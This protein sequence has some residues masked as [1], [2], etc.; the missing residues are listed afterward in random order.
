MFRLVDEK[1]YFEVGELNIY[2]SSAHR[3]RSKG[4]VFG[5][6]RKPH[7]LFRNFAVSQFRNFCNF[8]ARENHFFTLSEVH[9]RELLYYYY[10]DMIPGVG[11]FSLCTKPVS[12]ALY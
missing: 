1:I 6:S 11:R 9:V 4:K 2:R 10:I 7:T 5:I 3:E 8:A 12:S